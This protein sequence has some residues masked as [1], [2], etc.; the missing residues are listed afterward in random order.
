MQSD[1]A[2]AEFAPGHAIRQRARE[3]AL[4]QVARTKVAK[5]VRSARRQNRKYAPGQWVYVFRRSRALGEAGTTRRDRWVGPGPVVLQSGH[6]IWVAGRSRRWK[7][8]TDQVRHAT[9]TEAA[10]AELIH[11]FDACNLLLEARPGQRTGAIDVSRGGAL[12]SDAWDRPVQPDPAA[13]VGSG[14]H[15]VPPERDPAQVAEIANE[16]IRQPLVEAAQLL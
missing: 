10:G 14:P 2:G 7:C 16:T 8:S 5:A 3:L 13:G 6:I 11:H 9:S 4:T 15:R 12:P 1:T